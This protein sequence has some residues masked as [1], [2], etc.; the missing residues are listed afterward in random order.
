MRVL[1]IDIG[2]S[3]VKAAV[4]A[5]ERPVG[6]PATVPFP[7]RF[8]GRRAEVEPARIFRAVADS[9]AELGAAARKVDVVAPC[10]MSPSWIAMDARGKPLTRFVTHQ[11]RRSVQEARELEQRVGLARYLGI[12]GNRPIPGGISV[13]TWCWFARHEP[14][15]VRRASLVGHVTTWLLRQLTGERVVDPSHASFMG[16][17]RTVDQGGWSDELCEAAGVPEGVLPEIRQ[18]SQVAGRIAPEGARRSGIV[19]GTP[20]LGGCVDTSAAFF[21]AGAKVGQL[22]NVAGSTDV[23]A[24]CT[25]R[26]R[27]HERLLTRALGVGRRWLS[28]STLAAAGSSIAWAREQ[29]FRDL[30]EARFGALVRRLA[31]GPAPAEVGFEPYLAGDRMSIEQRRGALTGLSLATTREHILAAII[32]TLVEASAARI[33]LMRSLVMKIGRNVL[34]GG[35]VQK[36]LGKLLYRDWPGK[37]SFSP[38]ADATVR[39]MAK[40]AEGA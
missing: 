18:T 1:A 2:S 39:G 9:V 25:D 29:L 15:V 31:A 28:V 22:V 35:G 40:L 33:M 17:Y 13:T 26:F 20:V 34:V 16:L 5:G 6:R 7:T 14:G 21:L 19:E 30:T 8:D 12:A 10:G 38:Q 36:G 3:S 11:D 27:P 24:L 23:L 32:H 37:W 4:L